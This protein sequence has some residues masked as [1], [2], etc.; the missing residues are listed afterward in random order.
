MIIMKLQMLNKTFN[1]KDLIYYEHRL[2]NKKT[3]SYH[4]GLMVKKKKE[5]YGHHSLGLRSVLVH[6]TDV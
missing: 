4:F 6:M 2:W 3:Q 1:V 5:K